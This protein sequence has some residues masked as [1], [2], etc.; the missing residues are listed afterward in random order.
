MTVKVTAALIREKIGYAPVVYSSGYSASTGYTA[1][2]P[3]SAVDECVFDLEKVAKANSPVKLELLDSHWYYSF[4]IAMDLSR[5]TMSD[6]LMNSFIEAV[7]KF[8]SQSRYMAA[9]TGDAEE[10]LCRDSYL[11]DQMCE[12]VFITNSFTRSNAG[13]VCAQAVDISGEHKT[14]YRTRLISSVVALYGRV[15]FRRVK[16]WGRQ[17][18]RPKQ[19]M[20]NDNL[21]CICGDVVVAAINNSF[22]SNT[23]GL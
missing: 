2:T 14:Y 17:T 7:K 18:V 9:T 20:S 13:D 4:P 12:D 5:T 23:V 21:L 11:S 22:V 6:H 10:R 3:P 1:Y 15:T 8:P 16:S 19:S